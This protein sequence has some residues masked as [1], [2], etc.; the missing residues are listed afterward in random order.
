MDSIGGEIV[1]KKKVEKRAFIRGAMDGTYDT[2]QVAWQLDVDERTVREL[3]RRYRE[4]GENA[5]VHGNSGRRPAN[6]IEESLRTRIVDLKKSAAY[7]GVKAIRFR[8][9][10]A[11]FEGIDI[12]YSSLLNILKGARIAL[13]ANAGNKTVAFGEMLE[14]AAHS[15]DWFWDGTPR[16]LY[17]IADNATMHITSLYFCQNECDKGYT[18]VLRQTV[19][20]YGIPRELYAEK[21]KTLFA[22]DSLLG[23]IVQKLG[24]DIA[25]GAAAPRAKK[26]VK[27]LL[28][29]LQKQL[30][31][32][33]KEQD[34]TDI[35]QANLE[36]RRFIDVFNGQFACKPQAPE[37]Y[38]VPLGEHD[39]DGIV[40]T[41]FEQNA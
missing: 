41:T 3:K 7:S 6:Y 34:I 37:S 1:G 18:E 15:Y 14:M 35:E 21:A 27:H 29:T 28:K 24:A 25:D 12:S 5:L 8:D 39:W 19:T 31:I 33:L 40:R 4:R 22:G 26:H 38:F 10:L 9:L 13:K 17:V 11:E 16:I 2:D 23:S 20:D 36:L 32:W 30:P